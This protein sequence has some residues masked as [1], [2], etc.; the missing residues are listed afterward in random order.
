[1]REKNSTESDILGMVYEGDSFEILDKN[2]GWYKI[3]SK[4]GNGWVSGVYVR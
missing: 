4:V 2:N 3:K 1:M